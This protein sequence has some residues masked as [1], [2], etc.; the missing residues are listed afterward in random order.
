MVT[1][2]ARPATWRPLSRRDDPTYEAPYSGLPGW[3]TGSLLD[4]M[5]RDLRQVSAS[6]EV[7]FDE[8]TLR[9]IERRLRA[10]LSWRTGPAEAYQFLACRMR[11]DP[12]FAFDVI[13]LLA[14]RLKGDRGRVRLRALDQILREGGSAWTVAIHDGVPRLD[15]RV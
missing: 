2:V 4:W 10:P 14:S 5:A 8:I 13:D 6:G 7:S 11:H 9:E 3:L 12:D 1:P 15:R